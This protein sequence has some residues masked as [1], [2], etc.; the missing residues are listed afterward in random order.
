MSFLGV[1]ILDWVILGAL[2]LLGVEAW[3]TCGPAKRA[4]P[5]AAEPGRGNGPPAR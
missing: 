3:L 4:P 2:L 5:G 1:P